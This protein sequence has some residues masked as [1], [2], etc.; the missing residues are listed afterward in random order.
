MIES[1]SHRTTRLETS[2]RSAIGW[3]HSK[4]EDDEFSV[5]HGGLAGMGWPVRVHEYTVGNFQIPAPEKSRR[6]CLP[7]ET[8]PVGMRYTLMP[9][10]GMR[11]G[12]MSDQTPR[13]F[14]V[15]IS[16]ILYLIVIAALSAALVSQQL[17]IER[18]KR[19]I[20]QHLEANEKS[21]K[22]I[23]ERTRARYESE[24]SLPTTPTKVL[25]SQPGR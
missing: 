6:R 13:R 16:T 12:I 18:M 19:S 25:N 20:R 17:Q 22:S 24:R 10:H 4:S 23:L 14:R 2:P 9:G 8:P 3:N 1:E 7:G 21:M 15:R 11:E 5:R